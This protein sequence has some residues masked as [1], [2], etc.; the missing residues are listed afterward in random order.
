[1][2]RTATAAGLVALALLVA[3]PVAANTITYEA[4][5]KG[6]NEVPPNASPAT[7]YALLTLDDILNT[8]TVDETFSGLIGGNAAAAHIHC[9]A[10]AGVN[11]IV[12]VGFPGFPPAASGHYVQTFVL[13]NASTYTAAYIAAHGATVATAEADLIAALNSGNAYVNIHNTVFGG[14]EIR[15]QIAATLPEPASMTLL[16]TGIAALVARRR[17]TLRRR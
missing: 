1:M 11:A 14:G 17:R 13:T 2:L 6:T 5:L 3:A 16:G 7:G 9:C 12:A 15:G 10:P 4:Y 8:L